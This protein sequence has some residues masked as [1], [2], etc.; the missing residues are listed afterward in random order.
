M[1][2]FL[3]L[4]LTLFLL[5]SVAACGGAP[6]ES[7]SSE[8][9][10]VDP[11]AYLTDLFH[12]IYKLEERDGAYGDPKIGGGAFVPMRFSH[13]RMAAYAEYNETAAI[14]IP[15]YG[16]T[17]GVRMDFYTDADTVSFHYYV[18]DGFFDGKTEY[19]TDTFNIFEN[20]E[21]QSSQ[22]VVKGVAG[23]VIY[24]RKSTEAESRITIVFPNYHGVSLSMFDLGN[25]RPVED[26]D[27][28]ILFFGDSISQGLFA[29]RPADAFTHQ[30]ATALNA[31]Y[32]NLAVGGEIFRSEALDEEINF[33][34]T[35]IVVA[36]GTNDYYGGITVD[37]VKANAYN[38]LNA[39][40][41]LYPGIPVTVISPFGNFS[42]QYNEA[43]E[44]AAQMTE[45][46]Y[47][48]GST[49]ISRNLSSWYP[50]MV[51]PSSAGF[52]EITANLTSILKEQLG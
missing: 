15:Y 26:Y 7:S 28:K 27:H 45:C 14:K 4:L 25:T 35:Y 49:L 13:E 42:P 6:A 37:N 2:R 16:C 29:D 52:A 11:N 3:S 1:K 18:T 20:G 44:S 40:K 24:S 8:P 41:K 43:I 36:L 50:D 33:D 17:A 5:L 47:V 34:P 32:M 31:D 22:N 38:Y 21:Y 23:D 19:A 12:G 39:V 48:D 9:E 30:T 51:H 10:I 46:H